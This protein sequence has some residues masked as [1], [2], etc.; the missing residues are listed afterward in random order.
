MNESKARPMPRPRRDPGLP[1]ERRVV[2]D[3]KGETRRLVVEGG[4]D[5]LGDL[6]CAEECLPKL[7]LVGDHCL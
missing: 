7:V 4:D 5:N 6:P 3:E 1:E 2:V